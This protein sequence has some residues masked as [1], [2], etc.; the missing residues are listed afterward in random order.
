M[1]GKCSRKEKSQMKAWER[2][3][4]C[5]KGRKASL[6][7]SRKMLGGKGASCVFYGSWLTGA[8]VCQVCACNPST[9]EADAGRCW[10]SLRPA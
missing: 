1:G 10:L 2:D 4:M 3:G 7:D 8:E 5:L 9:R 6:G